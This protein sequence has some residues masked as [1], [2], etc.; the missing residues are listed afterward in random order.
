MKILSGIVVVVLIIGVAIIF[1]AAFTPSR[2]AVVVNTSNSVG[3][4]YPGKIDLAVK[5]L[6]PNQL[7]S[8]SISGNV[9]FLN[10][11]SPVDYVATFSITGAQCD[12]HYS[13]MQTGGWNSLSGGE[14]V[15][16]TSTIVREINVSSSPQ[17]VDTV[18]SCPSIMNRG[19]T[20]E[21]LVVNVLPPLNASPISANSST[22]Q[23]AM[24]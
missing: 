6:E 11:Y 20:S 15:N 24:Q 2:Q 12:Y 23:T 16:F 19:Y 18:V 13:G 21:M 10:V 22:V 17:S 8:T 3:P 9:E 7:A 1:T 5:V 4:T 14:D